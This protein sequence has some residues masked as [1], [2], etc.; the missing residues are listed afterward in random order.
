MNANLENMK[1]KRVLVVGLGKSGIAAS[2]AMLRLG[3]EVYIQDSKK[4]ETVDA[5]LVAFLKGRGVRCYF[6]QTPPDMGAFDMLILSPG[7]S[8]ELPFIQEAKD[9]GAEIIGELEIAYRIGSGNYIAI[10]GT[11]GKTTT[12]T[13]VGEIF[14]AAKRKTYV[15]GNIGVAVI[16]ASMDAAS[17]DWL[18]TETSSFQLET[19]RYFK[20]VVSAILNLTPDHLNRHHTMKAYGEAKAKI[21]ANQRDDG[22]LVINYDDKTCYKLA[23]DCQAT[24]VPFSRKNQLSFGA[25]L[26]DNRLVIRNKQ[27]ELV[28]ICGSDELKIIGTHNLENALAAAAICYFAGIDAETIGSTIKSFSGVAHRIEFC[29]LIEGV[30]YY[31]DSKGTNIDAAI[32]AIRAIEKNIILIAG[33]DAKG[34]T[35]D[36]FIS[37]FNG[38]VKKMILLGRDGRLIAEAADRKGFTDYVYCKDMQECVNKAYELAEPGDTV[39]LSPACAS[40]D[41]YD[42]FEQRGEHFKNCVSRL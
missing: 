22:Y 30:N 20:P 21:F 29:G 6:A 28:D 15:V 36:E 38:S 24:I 18:V 32:T 40:W 33:G 2:Q 39:L 19:T 3:A 5:Q 10:T 27:G 25:F 4:E 9:K 42:N 35:F 7:V 23:S 26:Q 11:N 31:N 12:T 37:Q 16:S 8:P 13:L 34:Q 1:Y 41:M 14:K 17:E